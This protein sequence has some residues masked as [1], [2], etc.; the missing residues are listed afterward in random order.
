MVS[1]KIIDDNQLNEIQSRVDAFCCPLDIGRIPYKL[2][3]N[4]SGLKADQ[5]KNWTL[6]FSSYALKNILL[7]QDY[8][9]HLDL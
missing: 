4:A 6:Y 2:A 8:N 7:H 9:L 1:K 3:S 5:W